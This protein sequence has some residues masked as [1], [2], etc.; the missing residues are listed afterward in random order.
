[1]NVAIID[2]GSNSI[3]LL[4][5]EIL[6]DTPFPLHR[7]L[8][9]TRLGRGVAKD[10]LLDQQSMNDT[11]KALITMKSEA[12]RWN[13]KKVYVFATSALR[14]AENSRKF[15]KHIK[16]QTGVDVD[17][18]SGKDE[19]LFSFL[20]ARGGISDL[21]KTAIIDVGGGSTELSLGDSCL[22]NS[23]SLPMGA[24][25]FTDMYLRSDP[26]TSDELRK[27]QEAVDGLMTGF[28]RIYEKFSKG[29][30][31]SVL[32]VGGT[33][34]TLAAICQGLS[35]YDPVKIHGFHLLREDINR[36]FFKLSA[37]TVDERKSVPGLPSDRADI[38]IAGALIV[39]RIVE[40][41]HIVSI[42][43]SEA[44]LM[45]G[46]ITAKLEEIN[47]NNGIS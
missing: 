17:V 11:I 38:I 33:L 43:V 26:P 23:K 29:A 37:L 20:G 15:L 18:L 21:S 39:R 10:K 6:G 22:L 14:E 45:E 1:M 16:E 7:K 36:L 24:V 25:R 40:K 35:F 19:A 12:A 3:R 27:A 42:Q 13:C 47:R 8:I 46:Y 41:L 4:V 2:M 31:V 30:K 28:L 34:T 32:G 5:V 9:V 44:D